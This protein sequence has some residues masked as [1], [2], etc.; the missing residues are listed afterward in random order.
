MNKIIVFLLAFALLL[1]GCGKS[2]EVEESETLGEPVS[3]VRY[4]SL[5]ALVSAAKNPSEHDEIASLSSL[6]NISVPTGIPDGYSLYKVTAGA[7]DIAFWYLPNQFL[8]SNDSIL[9]AEAEQKHFMFI[10]G[11]ESYG[12]DE[13]LE[14]FGAERTNLIKDKYYVTNTSRQ[15]VIWEDSDG[16]V[17]MLYLPKDFS[18]SFTTTSSS[19]AQLQP[20][21]TPNNIEDYCE[22]ENY[23]IQRDSAVE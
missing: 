12:F 7:V 10:D 5:D 13:V 18:T 17:L 14:Q 19:E 22:V 21:I 4:D 2:R 1:S 11:R 3:I 15:K 16:S 23:V 9:S 8:T 20:I 6:D